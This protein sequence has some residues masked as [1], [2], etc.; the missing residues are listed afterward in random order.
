MQCSSSY[1]YYNLLL[2]P[3]IAELI[4]KLILHDLLH[5]LLILKMYKY[6]YFYFYLLLLLLASRST[7]HKDYI[8]IN[9]NIINYYFLLLKVQVQAKVGIRYA[10]YTTLNTLPTTLEVQT[11]TANNFTCSFAANS[12]Y[13]F[14]LY[15]L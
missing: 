4:S 9:I 14:T 3:K 6:F 13:R 10:I 15:S 5:D 2:K 7:K 11:T 12:D 1:I 8:N